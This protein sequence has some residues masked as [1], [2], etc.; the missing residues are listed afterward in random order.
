M[1][2]IAVFASG[3]GT[4][5]EGI[6]NYFEDSDLARVFVVFCNRK[7]AGVVDRARLLGV[8]C[9]V[10]SKEG[11]QNGEVLAKLKEYKIDMIVL[12]G[13]LL[14]VPSDIIQQF[15]DRIINLHP[16]L[17]PDYG[18]DGMYGMHVHEAVVENEEEET[19]ITIHYVNDDY[20][21]GEIIFQE[22]VEVDYEDTPEDVQYK[23][24]QLEHKHYPE[25]IEYVIKD[26]D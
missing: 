7:N 6:V 14:K 3:N 18:G 9:I 23:V 1:K 11:L 22:T 5:T 26:L 16:A 15:P 25:V 4:N 20:D 10:F 8:R 21:E 2:R 17:L 13:F 24:Q 19:G 12:A